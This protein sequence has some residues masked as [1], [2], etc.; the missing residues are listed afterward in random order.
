MIILKL[1]QES[2]LLEA[3]NDS[4]FQIVPYNMIPI[5]EINMLTQ[6]KVSIG[7]RFSKQFQ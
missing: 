6:F 1:S 2:L 4:I 3:Q 7:F 5:E